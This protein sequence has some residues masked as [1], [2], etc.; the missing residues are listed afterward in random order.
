MVRNREGGGVG[1]MEER[2]KSQCYGVV[3]EREGG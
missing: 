1:V 2:E 3:V